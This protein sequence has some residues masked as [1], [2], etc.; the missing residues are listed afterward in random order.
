MKY[1]ASNLTQVAAG[2]L[3]LKLLVLGFGMAEA[4]GSLFILLALESQ[5]VIAYLFP[6]R[7][8]VFAEI[9]ELQKQLAEIKDKEEEHSRE[10]TALRFAQAKK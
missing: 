1:L 3:L 7:P 9:T 4:A 10:I 2:L 6:K 8:D 5:K